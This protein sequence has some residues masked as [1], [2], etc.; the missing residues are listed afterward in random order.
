[1][2][3]I[4]ELNRSSD[5]DAGKTSPPNGVPHG[6]GEV[7]RSGLNG[8]HRDDSSAAT[9]RS[10]QGV[11]VLEH[12][13]AG[14]EPELRIRKVAWQPELNRLPA[15][16]ARGVL[17]EQIR[18]LRSRLHELRLDRPLKTVIVTSGLPGEGKS[19]V[20]SNLALGFSRF[21]NQRVL[22]IDADM[23]RGRL[24]SILGAPQEPGLTDYLSNQATL[25]Q[26]LQQMDLPES[27]PLN[28]SLASLSFI[29]S[30]P[31]ADNAAD[32]SGNGRFEILLKSVYD[33]FDWIIVDSSPVTLVADGVNLARACDGVV[34]VTRA[35]VTR[36]EIAQRAQQELK[37]AKIVGVVLNAIQDAPQSGGYYGYDG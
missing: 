6:A 3:R 7:L 28:R 9:M 11:S 23:R 2:D 13:A 33:Y 31:D 26:V 12:A 8:K 22:L 25:E 19:F 29:A 20:A 37:A 17:V 1:M 21:R 24:N 34:L 36:Y 18:V 14:A 4:A 32:L 15:L 27:G 16:E 10:G 5:T 35:G 30:G